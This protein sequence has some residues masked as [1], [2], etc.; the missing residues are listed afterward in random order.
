L[1]VQACLYSLESK[2]PLIA[3]CEGRCLTLFNDPLVDSL[4]TIY[5]E[6][7]VPHFLAIVYD[8][9]HSIMLF[10]FFFLY[11]NTLQA[12]IMPSVEHLLASADI[13]VFTR[14]NSCSLNIVLLLA[15]IHCSL[16]KAFFHFWKGGMTYNLN[17]MV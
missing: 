6:P 4:H 8:F 17:L 16:L 10:A 1:Y 2:V 9:L 3:F 14:T 13:Q 7:K 11:Q 5:H 15:A 12:E